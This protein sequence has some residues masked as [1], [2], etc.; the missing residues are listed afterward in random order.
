VGTGAFGPS[1]TVYSATVNRTYVDISKSGDTAESHYMVATDKG[2]FEVDNS[3]L[4]NIYNADEIYGK[5]R[6]GHTYNFGVQGKKYA[7]IFL[8]EYPYIKWVEAVATNR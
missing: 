8:Q 2:V 1:S 5:I 7:N 3:I 4:M 6:E